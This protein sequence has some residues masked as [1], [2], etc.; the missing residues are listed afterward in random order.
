MKNS[1]LI[2][3][4]LFISGLASGKDHV[5]I[6]KL[7]FSPVKD[8]IVCGV[9]NEM[10]VTTEYNNQQLVVTGTNCTISVKDQKKGIYAVH[11]PANSVG[12]NAVITISVKNKNGSLTKVHSQEVPVV[13]LS[14]RMQNQYFN[15]K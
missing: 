4:F 5:N 9:E 11:A 7:K 1:F 14:L 8:T 13:R 2:L 15:K 12:K 10:I 6:V 3:I